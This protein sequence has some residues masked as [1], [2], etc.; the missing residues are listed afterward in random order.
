MNFIG[1]KRSNE[2]ENDDRSFSWDPGAGSHARKC[3]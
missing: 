2:K 3:H 1:G